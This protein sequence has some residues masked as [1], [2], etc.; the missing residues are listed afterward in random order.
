VRDVWRRKK[1]VIV[2][3]LTMT[4]WCLIFLLLGLL[5]SCLEA[6]KA[7]PEARYPLNELQGDFDQLDNLITGGHPQYF[8][9]RQALQG[10]LRAQRAL[11]VDGMTTIEFFR[12]VAP[13][14]AMVKCGHTRI[15]LPPA[16]WDSLSRRD[17]FLP[18]EIKV[19]DGGLFVQRNLAGGGDVPPGAVVLAID[20]RPA[21]GIIRLMKAGLPADGDNDTYKLYAM[22]HQF[23]KLY[24]RLVDDA[25][26]FTVTIRETADGA[27]RQ[28]VLP[29][30][31][32]RRIAELTTDRLGG[33]STQ[34]R[35]ACEFAGGGSYAVLR[36][37]DFGYYGDPEVFRRPVDAFFTKVK[38][39]GIGAVIL[40]LRGNDGGDPYCSSFLAN[41][42]M[43]RPL[44]YFAPGTR[45]Y[46]DLVRPLPVPANVFT[47][48]LYVLIDGWCFSSTGHLCALLK[49]HG[50]GVFIGEE[51]GG[52]YACN[53]ASSSH[54]LNHTGIELNLP[55]ETFRVAV[56]GL[57]KGRG[58][59]PDIP[60]QPTISD[61]IDGRDVV[62]E[63]AEA[64]IQRQHPD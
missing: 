7:D 53:D 50:V 60:V 52:S 37:A 64:L 2:S 55:N 28:V 1:E 26:A 30:L 34:P 35:L 12:V 36:V 21:Q 57:T 22:N 56:D 47:G 33:G 9:D 63:Q 15:S 3:G 61:L 40:D 44:V 16:L 58:I 42:L 49:H 59:L 24:H 23:A 51:T 54:V 62:M 6:E 29:A 41:H 27:E 20:G 17:G 19:I 25:E 38:Q 4:R 10:A 8:T 48:A 45:H 14:A 39:D 32:W 46:D 5:P 11:L 13:V 43:D 31:N 18:L